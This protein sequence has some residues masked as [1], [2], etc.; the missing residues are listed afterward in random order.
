MLLFLF[1]E[2]KMWCFLVSQDVDVWAPWPAPT[3]PSGADDTRLSGAR[4]D[5]HLGAARAAQVY[6]ITADGL[7]GLS[8]IEY[9]TSRLQERKTGSDWGRQ[10]E[11]GEQRN[12][13]KVVA[14]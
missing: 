1:P 3:P 7:L 12:A 4:P 2:S 9:P 6:R 5:V 8:M 11:K 10:E 14:P 13:E